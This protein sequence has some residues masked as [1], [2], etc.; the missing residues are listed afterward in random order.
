MAG[1]AAGAPR[2]MNIDTEE[3]TGHQIP[4][5]S[6]TLLTHGGTSIGPF[7]LPNNIELIT[8]NR[9]GQYMSTYAVK[10]IMQYLR[11]LP[12]SKRIR[13]R[14]LRLDYPEL[15]A[16]GQ[17]THEN[18]RI[19][20]F[21]PYSTGVPNQI[22]N[23][24]NG[25]QDVVRNLTGFFDTTL[26][27]IN[28][29]NN[30]KISGSFRLFDKKLIDTILSGVN[31]NIYTL[32]LVIYMISKYLNEHHPGKRLR[33]Y[34]MCCRTG[35]PEEPDTDMASATFTN[36][37]RSSHSSASKKNKKRKR[38]S[39]SNKGKTAKKPKLSSTK[40]VRPA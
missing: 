32:Q 3:V 29:T 11:R 24:S 39:P 36:I 28:L 22:L 10:K 4:F 35:E 27:D 37:L 19:S 31:T 33:L 6:L 2:N 26:S 13:S 15:V 21:E 23:L 14:V 12:N 1:A 18:I 40:R 30:T 8:F 38:S 20:Y 34:L 5:R 25:P 7:S 9:P 16:P 17:H